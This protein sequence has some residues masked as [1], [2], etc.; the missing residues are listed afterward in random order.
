M[1][2][3]AAYFMVGVLIVSIDMTVF[4]EADRLDKESYDSALDLIVLLLFAIDIP[5]MMASSFFIYDRLSIYLRAFRPTFAEPVVHHVPLLLG[6]S[7]V[8]EDLLRLGTDF[9]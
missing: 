8:N 6:I 3:L 1:K 2:I 4:L 5:F 7:E 9:V